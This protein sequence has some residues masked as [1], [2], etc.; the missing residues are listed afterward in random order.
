MA[1]FLSLRMWRC[2]VLWL[3]L[4]NQ[5][6]AARAFGLRSV[7]LCSQSCCTLF[8]KC[9]S[10]LFSKNLILCVFL[11]SRLSKIKLDM[12]QKNVSDWWSEQVVGQAIFP[13][14]WSTTKQVSK[15]HSLSQSFN[16][17]NWCIN[18]A[19]VHCQTH[20]MF[21]NN[22]VKVLARKWHSGVFLPDVKAVKFY[23]KQ[24]CSAEITSITSTSSYFRRSLK[25]LTWI[26]G[27][28]PSGASDGQFQW[29]SS[30]LP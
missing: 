24:R 26:Y 12:E 17:N 3:M 6:W 7:E 22:I 1:A 14:W 28:Q 25:D 21:V 9:S 13:F 11:L 15:M 5:I 18:L 19:Y 20:Q 8:F 23:T 10:D 4:Q 29:C 27:R 2:S 16:M 30:S